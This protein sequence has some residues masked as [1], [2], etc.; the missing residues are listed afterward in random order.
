MTGHHDHLGADFDLMQ[1]FDGTDNVKNQLI[2]VVGNETSN[3][4]DVDGGGGGG[5]LLIP[6]ALDDSVWGRGCEE[7]AI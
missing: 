4:N 7:M 2:S 3:D 1:D 5:S 6:E